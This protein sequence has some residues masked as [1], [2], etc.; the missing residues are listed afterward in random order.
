MPASRRVGGFPTSLVE[1]KR[2]GGWDG[3]APS[4][5]RTTTASGPTH[6]V[7]AGLRM[8][9]EGRCWVGAVIGSAAEYFRRRWAGYRRFPTPRI[10]ARSSSD[11]PPQMPYGSRVRRA[12]RRHSSRTGQPWQ[13]AFA[14]SIRRCFW[15]LR[16]LA[17]W[18]NIS[19][20][21]PRHVASNCQFHSSETGSRGAGSIRTLS[22]LSPR[23][24]REERAVSL[25]PDAGFVRTGHFSDWRRR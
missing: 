8:G 20:F 13:I 4:G 18:K 12:C 3:S 6:A 24:D 10:S 17:G 19:T 16:S 22:R 25:V 15:C 11:S 2:R 14:W 23:N 1:F 21:M 5:W 9:G 7:L